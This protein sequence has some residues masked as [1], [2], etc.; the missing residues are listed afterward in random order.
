MTPFLQYIWENALGFVLCECGLKDARPAEGVKR[1][2][3]CIFV[4]VEIFAGSNR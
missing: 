2:L 1:V 3:S 4:V